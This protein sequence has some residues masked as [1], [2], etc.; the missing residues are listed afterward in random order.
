MSEGAV[1]DGEQVLIVDGAAVVDG[2]GVL[3]EGAVSD[4]QCA[5]VRD[6]AASRGIA[7]GD[8]QVVE[9]DR[10]GGIDREHFV[11]A[12]AV[13]SDV[14]QAA[15]DGERVLDHGQR[16]GQGDGAADAEHDQVGA[17]ARGAVTA[18]GVAFAIGVADRLAQAAQAVAGGARIAQ[19]VDGYRILAG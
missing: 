4:G 13:D 18:A 3:G 19:R 10:G 12:A 16:A 7:V 2:G 17:G 8:G 5:E 14:L 9:D 1:I 6:A 11:E 15:V